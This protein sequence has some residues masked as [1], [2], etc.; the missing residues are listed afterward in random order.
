MEAERFNYFRKDADCIDNCDTN[1][2]V[3]SAPV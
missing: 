2:Y 1:I 3:S